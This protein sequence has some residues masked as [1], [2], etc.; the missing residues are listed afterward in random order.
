MVGRQRARPA[1]HALYS[2]VY[3]H[4]EEEEP[5][6]T[7]VM[8]GNP[9]AFWYATR[10]PALVVP[11][12]DLG[13]VLEVCARYGVQYLLLDHNHPPPLGDVYEGRVSS[14]RLTPIP[15]PFTGIALW[16]IEP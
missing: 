7:I 1:T 11:N 12:E 8:V 4:I 6:E 14:P 5:E 16:R 10:Q 9:P 2:G 3:E 15:I 13:T